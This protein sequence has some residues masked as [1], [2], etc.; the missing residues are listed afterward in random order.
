MKA[1]DLREEYAALALRDS[2]MPVVY[3]PIKS[4]RFGLSLGLN[5]LSDE[6]KACSFNCGYCDLGK[7]EVR[8]NK[9]KSEIS[10]LSLDQLQ[11]ELRNGLAQHRAHTEKIESLL[12]SGNGEPTIYP[13]FPEAVAEILKARNEFLPDAKI[14]ILTNG[15]HLDS[16]KIVEALNLLDDRIVKID[17]GNEKLFKA[18]NAPLSRASLSSLI[19]NMKSLKDFSVQAMFVQG[20]IDNTLPADLED[21]I[22]VLGLLRPKKVHIHTINRVPSQ[23]GLKPVD[24]DTLYTIASRLERRT[25]IKSLV[26][27]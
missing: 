10:F 15:A 6:K 24:E 12:L 11:I 3:G 8:L 22:E 17:V 25:Q 26:F 27:P 13:L 1:M 4:R 7:S 20:A 2:K 21:W 9:I 23:T 14:S 5:I 19:S 16:R 18:M